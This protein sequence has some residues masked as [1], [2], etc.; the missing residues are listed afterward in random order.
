MGS[1]FNHNHTKLQP[2][3]NISFNNLSGNLPVGAIYFQ[4]I[5]GNTS[6]IFSTISG[7]WRFNLNKTITLNKNNSNNIIS[8]NNECDVYGL[9]LSNNKYDKIKYEDIYKTYKNINT[10]TDDTYFNLPLIS[11]SNNPLNQTNRTKNIL[12]IPVVKNFKYAGTINT[13]EYNIK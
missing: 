11:G 2:N 13:K 10:L 9:M 7:N 5:S 8:D 6:D 3:N 1:I 4:T 12:T